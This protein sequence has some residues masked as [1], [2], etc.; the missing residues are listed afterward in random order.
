[1]KTRMFIQVV[2]IIALLA[3]VAFVGRGI[4]AIQPPGPADEHDHGENDAEILR[5]PKGGRLLGEKEFQVEVTIYEPEGLDPNFRLYFYE[6]G[7]PLD[8][9]DIKATIKLQRINRAETVTFAREDAFLAGE[10]PVV[11][12]HSFDAVVVVDRGGKKH[13]WH[14]Q[15]IEARVEISEE[16]RKKAG[17]GVET[18]G[19]AKIAVRLDLNGKIAP[20]E[21]AMTHVIPRFPGVV[22]SVRK[23]LGDRVARGDVLATVES[24]ESL[25][26]YEI[27][28]EIDGT[29]IMRHVT[30]GEFVSG[31]E[32]IFTVADLSTVWADFAVY[33]HDFPRLRAGQTV[34]LDGGAG[35]ETAEAKIDYISPFGS[36]N[37]QTMLARASVQNRS[38]AWR[39]GLFVRGSVI[40]EQVEVPVAVK[41][42]ALQRF[43]DRDVVFLRVGDLFEA[44]PVEVGRRNGD[45][46][47]IT[48]GLTAGEQYASDNSFIV[49]ADAGKSGATHDH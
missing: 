37:S 25:R 23:R 17:I 40:V 12:P 10:Q 14:F 1:M 43:R 26:T 15:T 35:L 13:E 21:D 49:K 33:R 39:P 20:N 46:V 45:R 3:G 22:K 28:A 11:E 16:S 8:P 6:S 47:E 41:A 4:L 2:V 36:E 44:V 31:Q 42:T 7:K 24:N 32:P 30:V 19:A 18:A 48:S 5:G 38:G 9:A 27:T 29:I 34:V